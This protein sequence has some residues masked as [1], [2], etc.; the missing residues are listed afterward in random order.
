MEWNLLFFVKVYSILSKILLFLQS[1]PPFLLHIF[2][3]WSYRSFV[4]WYAW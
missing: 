2:L 3:Q 4:Y 1:D